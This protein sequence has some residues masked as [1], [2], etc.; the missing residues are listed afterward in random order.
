M[1][2]VL[3]RWQDEQV[4]EL[5]PQS[6]IPL[7][8]E[9]QVELTPQNKV[10]VLENQSRLSYACGEVFEIQSQLFAFLNT[11]LPFA[12]L[13][14]RQASVRSGA[15]P[16]LQTRLSPFLRNAVRA[17]P[18]PPSRL[19]K[20]HWLGAFTAFFKIA[21]ACGVV[22]LAWEGA[23]ASGLAIAPELEKNMVEEA[24]QARMYATAALLDQ[25]LKITE[26]RTRGA[27]NS[28]ASLSINANHK[29]GANSSVG[30]DAS[31]SRASVSHAHANGKKQNCNLKVL[32]IIDPDVLK[33][34]SQA[35]LAR[36]QRHWH[37]A[38]KEC[39]P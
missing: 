31:L 20:T 37:R 38:K 39:L 8:E 36:L 23:H 35:E 22:L 4:L 1:S 6:R 7:A 32:E 26:Q 18:Q 11:S 15:F 33:F 14:T 34:L 3:M 10:I 13:T 25:Q 30:A 28:S 5:R 29:A 9:I 21:A 16:L 2:T 27:Q 12:L 24:S 19:S 17:L